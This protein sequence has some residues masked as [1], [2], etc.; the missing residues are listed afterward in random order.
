MFI[1]KDD[2]IASTREFIISL[3]W[4]KQNKKKN[5]VIIIFDRDSSIIE[6]LVK[7]KLLEKIIMRRPNKK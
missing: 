7:R 3:T 2:V 5:C 4:Y 1:Q 6:L